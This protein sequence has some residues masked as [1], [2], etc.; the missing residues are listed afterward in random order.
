[1]E[2]LVLDDNHFLRLFSVNIVYIVK[3]KRLVKTSVLRFPESHLLPHRNSETSR[4]K[5][6]CITGLW[7][8]L[9]LPL[10][11]PFFRSQDLYKKFVV[12][13]KSFP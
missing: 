4:W 12:R 3:V 10:S 8:A 2:N 9:E 5:L 1:M 11:F 6:V 13:F 7:A